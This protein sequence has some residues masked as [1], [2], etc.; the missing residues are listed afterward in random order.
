MTSPPDYALQRKLLA[1]SPTM[2]SAITSPRC[3]GRQ[4]IPSQPS[5][6][7]QGSA[8]MSPETTQPGPVPSPNPPNSINVLGPSASGNACAQHLAILAMLCSAINHLSA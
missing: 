6:E 2:T 1:A 5:P 4:P 3:Q 7:W 8:V